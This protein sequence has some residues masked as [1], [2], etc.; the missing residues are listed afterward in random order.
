MIAPPWRHRS[1]QRTQIV[2]HVAEFSQHSGIVEFASGGITSSAE[3][4]RTG[5]AQYLPKTLRALYRGCGAWTF[6]RFTDNDGTVSNIE[7]QRHE[8]CNS[9]HGS[10]ITSAVRR[11]YSP[12]AALRF[13]TPTK[14]PSQN[15]TTPAGHAEAV[16]VLDVPW[17]T[18]RLVNSPVT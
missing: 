4:D 17:G 13:S 5:M 6:Y 15:K 7:R 8:I 1:S 9:G 10:P 11:S 16:F 12:R 2:R 18:S 14:M 3:C